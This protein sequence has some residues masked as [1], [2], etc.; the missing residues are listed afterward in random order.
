VGIAVLAAIAMTAAFVGAGRL[1]LHGTRPTLA[2]APLAQAP[3]VPPSG[4]ATVPTGP[5]A[6]S[7]LATGQ[8]DTIAAAVDPSIVDVNTTLGYR[9]GA[10]AGT[11]MI[12]T[13]A[14][15]ILTNNHVVDGAT[16]ITVTLVDTGRT[17]P[18]TVVGTDPTHDVAVIQIHGASGLKP[19]PMADSSSVG[20]GDAVVAIGNA[21]GAGGTPAVAT[22]NVTALDQTITVTDD[23]GANAQ[24]LSGLIQTDAPLQPGDSGGPLLNGSGQVIGID[25]A[26]SAGRRFRT[27]SSVGLAIPINQARA[28]AAQIQSGQAS[29]TT[30]I[31]LPGFLGVQIAPTAGSAVPGAVVAGVLAG[32]PAAAAGLGAGDVITAV[33]GQPITSPQALTAATASHHPGDKVTVGWTDSSG[34]QH[35]ATIVLASGPAN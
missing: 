24:T 9:G 10:G 1:Q 4:S 32:A 13:T 2:T 18:A 11:G 22:G 33:N 30:H 12:L 15:A 8:A 28:I 31:G 7:S 5:S 21:L 17:Y 23:T 25:T 6:D 14:G 35:H 20:V 26:A 27:G 3:V 34:T 16:S 19:I 29:A